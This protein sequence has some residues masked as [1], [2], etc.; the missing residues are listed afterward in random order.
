MAGKNVAGFAVITAFSQIALDGKTGAHS[1]WVS[2]V[3]VECL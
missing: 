1:L 2:G 3:N